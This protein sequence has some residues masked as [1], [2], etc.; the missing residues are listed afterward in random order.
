MYKEHLPFT[1]KQPFRQMHRIGRKIQRGRYIIAF[2][3]Y[4]IMPK[5]S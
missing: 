2:L 4:K 5:N 3:M 1:M